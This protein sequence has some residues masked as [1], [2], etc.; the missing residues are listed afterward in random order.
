MS[1]RWSLFFAVFLFGMMSCADSDSVKKDYWENGN[2]KSELRYQD[3]VLDGLCSWYMMNGKPQMEVTYKDNKMNGMLR[4]WYENGNLMEE[5]WYKAGVQDS[6]SRTY[7]INGAL[8]SEEYYVDGQLNGE[9]TRWY[10]NGQVFQEGRYT[11]G[12]MDGSWLIFYGDGNLA[13]KAD[14]NKGTGVQTS[15][16][17]SGYKCLVTNYVDNQKHG[18]E[19]YYNPDGAV[20]RV[21]IYE[22]GE[23]VRDDFVGQ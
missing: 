22:Y 13:A 5:S 16:D 3:G 4:R 1:V 2:L 18:K 11:D 14:F 10:D 17:H 9:Y 6:V 12:M 20:A 7:S 23:W 19:T 8:A 21:A 15:Y